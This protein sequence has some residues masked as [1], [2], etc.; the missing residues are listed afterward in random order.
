VFGHGP[1]IPSLNPRASVAGSDVDMGISVRDGSP[2]VEQL[3]ILSATTGIP[4]F[5]CSCYFLSSSQ[6]GNDE[7]HDECESMKTT[8]DDSDAGSDNDGSDDNDDRSQGSDGDDEDVADD[9]EDEDRELM[10]ACGQR[11][12][13]WERWEDQCQAASEA[14]NTTLTLSLSHEEAT[15]MKQQ[16]CQF[17][18]ILEDRFAECLLGCMCI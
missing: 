3:L 5:Y 6:S 10:I 14:I 12:G 8:D 1:I 4:Q 2:C 9:E 16:V 17:R 11:Q 13:R 7:E 18:R 15:A